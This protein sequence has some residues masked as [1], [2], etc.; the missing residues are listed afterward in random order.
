[1]MKICHIISGDL[2]AGAEVMCHSLLK[3]LKQYDNLTLHAILLNESKLTE[4]IKK[5]GI[6]VNIVNENEKS[7]INIV[8]ETGRILKNINPDIVHSHEYKENVISFLSSR[9]LR[10]TGLIATQHGMPQ[11][12][13]KGLSFNKMIVSS[14]N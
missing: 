11:F 13:N 9:L 1:M 8:A 14:C 10:N 5:L 4:E 3:G 2:W 7:F 12:I 6:R